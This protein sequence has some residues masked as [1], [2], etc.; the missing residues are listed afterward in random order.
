M[1]CGLDAVEQS[2]IV[3]KNRN[4]KD[5]PGR[6]KEKNQK[7]ESRGKGKEDKETQIKY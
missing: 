3:H 5:A 7:R 2:A 4:R 6:K 1:F